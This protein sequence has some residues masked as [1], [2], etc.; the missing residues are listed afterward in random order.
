MSEVKKQELLSAVKLNSLYLKPK[1]PEELKSPI[2]G[3]LPRP[4][5]HHEKFVTTAV[6]WSFVGLISGTVNAW[7]HD[8]RKIPFIKFKE[9]LRFHMKYLGKPWKVLSTFGLA[10]AAADWALEEF[11]GGEGKRSVQE[12]FLTAFLA[13]GSVA[14]VGIKRTDALK[15]AFSAGFLNSTVRYYNITSLATQETMDYDKKYY[16]WNAAEEEAP[17]FPDIEKSRLFYG[18]YYGKDQFNRYNAQRYSK[19][20]K[21]VDE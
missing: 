8:Y 1:K 13:A 15:L 12:R 3:F 9:S 5:N 4:K 6:G 18:A 14:L 19:G 16:Q 7:Y 20:V 10:Y 2:F 11:R 17:K 21:F